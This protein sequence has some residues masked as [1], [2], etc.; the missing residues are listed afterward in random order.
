LVPDV[1][2]TVTYE[3]LKLNRI[4]GD[5][6]NGLAEVS[7][8]FM[9]KRPGDSG[10]GILLSNAW[11]CSYTTLGS[12]LGGGCGWQLTGSTQC[13]WFAAHPALTY[14]LP[15]GQARVNPGGGPFRSFQGTATFTL[16]EGESFTVNGSLLET[17]IGV[18]DDCN[19]APFY[20]PSATSQRCVTNFNERFSYEDFADGG[21]ASFPT[22]DGSDTLNNC[23][24]EID[25]EIKTQ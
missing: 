8:F 19:F 24:W 20:T 10:N 21:Q 7:W 12:N 25:I 2:V 15:L 13:P 18:S 11:D 14:I 5:G 23:D 22:I 1:S 9:V 17:D 16:K 6:A 4:P 3:R